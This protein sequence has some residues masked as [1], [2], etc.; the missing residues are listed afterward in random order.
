MDKAFMRDFYETY[1]TDPYQAAI[2]DSEEFRKK[3]D[4]RYEIE[5][6]LTEMLG[7]A[8]T[9]EYKKFDE[10]LTAFLDEYD[11]LLVEMYLLGA[12]DREKMLR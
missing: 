8:G 7:G 1:Y 3:R 9:A 11:E 4:I 5:E 12:S 2:K 10:F 6:E